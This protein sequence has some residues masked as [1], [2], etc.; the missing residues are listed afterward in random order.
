[1]SNQTIE[2]CEKCGHTINS[3]EIQLFSGMVVA[4]FDIFQL[5]MK[6]NR[7]EFT[8]RELSSCIKNQNISARIGDWKLFGGLVYSPEGGHKGHYGL[9]LPRCEAFFSG[10]LEIPIKLSKSPTG[11]ITTLKRGRIRDIP[12]LHILL[13]GGAYVARYHAN[14]TQ[15]TL[16]PIQPE[17][18]RIR[19]IVWVSEAVRLIIN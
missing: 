16:S 3:R 9:N 19:E 12:H 11:E 15:M 14:P 13:E 10:T 6:E 4:L 17:D 5:C 2:R 18:L 1:M 7:H 8:R